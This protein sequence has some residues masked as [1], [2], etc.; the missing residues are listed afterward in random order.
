MGE[1]LGRKCSF[2][3]YIHNVRFIESTASHIILGGVAVYLLLSAN[4]GVIFAISRLS[5]YYAH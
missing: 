3:T 1:I 4:H 5:C 2:N